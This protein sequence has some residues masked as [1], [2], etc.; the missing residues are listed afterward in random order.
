MEIE[1]GDNR[2]IRDVEV[3]FMQPGFMDSPTPAGRYEEL[4]P[5][6]GV[7]VDLRAGFNGAVFDLEGITP[8]T[9]EV[10]VRYTRDGRAVEQRQSVTYDLHDKSAITWTDDRKMG[11]YITPSDSAVRNYTSF[12]RRGTT[13]NVLEGVSQPLQMAMLSYYALDELGIVY[14]LDPTSPFTEV[15]GNTALV[16]SVSLPRDTLTRLAGDC[17]DLT[18]LYCTMLETVGIETAFITTPGHIYA[19]VNTGVPAAQVDSIHPD[20]SRTLIV[21]GT[22]WVPVEVTMLGRGSFVEAWNYG[23]EVWQEME[24]D[25]G[26]RGFFRTRDAQSLYR[27]VGLRQ[28]D[29]GLQYGDMNQVARAFSGSIDRVAGEIVAQARAEAEERSDRRQWNDLGVLAA[30]WGQFDQA[31]DA[32]NRAARLDPAYVSPRINLGTVSFLQKDFSGALAAFEDAR[33]AV[34]GARRVRPATRATVLVNLARTQYELGQF[35]AAR[36]NY[37]LAAGEDQSVASQFA[38]L[39]TGGGSGDALQVEPEGVGIAAGPGGSAAA[40][41]RASDAA[42]GPSIL[43]AEG[44]E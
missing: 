36:E 5:G 41:G 2:T 20:R 39:D 18:A 38:Y 22:V 12:I 21:D 17:D 4:A 43:F 28:T 9:G 42:A 29:L 27:P 37:R 7:A 13:E 11:A 30:R 1:N 14:Q 26:L 25:P 8:V 34:E 35:D 24:S 31:R 33:R 23:V 40:T 19:A 6:E 44:D 32:F 3:L 15:Q 10:I 16:D